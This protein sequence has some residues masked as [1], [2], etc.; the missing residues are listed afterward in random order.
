MW[1]MKCAISRE[2]LERLLSEAKGAHSGEICGLLLGRNGF[3]DEAVSIANVAKDP[4]CSFLLDPAAHLAA[5]KKA[6]QAGRGIVGHYH[7][8]PGGN[9]EPS[10]ADAQAAEEQGLYWLI[11][12]AGEARLLIS[13]RGGEIL[14]AFG[15]IEIELF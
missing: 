9:P 13:R 7:S 10:P 8:H 3:I 11:L 1:R 6:R 4:E 15:G 5:S 12:A 2:V 14:G